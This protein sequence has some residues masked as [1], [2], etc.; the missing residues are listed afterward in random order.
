MQIEEKCINTIRFLAVDSIQ[1][2]NSGHPGMPLGCAPLAHLLFSRFMNHNPRNPD[3]WNRDRFV[4]SA[5][6][7]SMLLYSILHLCGY[8]LTLDDLKNFRQWGSKTPGHPEYGHTPGVET[9]TGPLG[10]GIANMVGMAVAQAFLAQ[11]FN[12]EDAILLDHFIYGIAGDGCMMEGISHEA[13]SFAG[14]NKLGKIILF[15]DDNK[16]TID[17]PVALSMSEDVAQRFM[18]Y[19][20]HVQNVHDVNDLD[21]V[22]RAVEEAKKNPAP[23]LIIT[24][25]EIGYGSPNKQAK[26]S[27][28]GSPLGIEETRLT[29]RNLGWPEDSSFLVP[30]DVAAFYLEVKAEGCRKESEWNAIWESYKTSHPEDAVIFSDLMNGY[31]GETWKKGLPVFDSG[32]SIATR[33]ASGKVLA[34]VAGLLPGIIGGSADLTPSN[35]THYKDAEDFSPENPGGRY[36]RFGIR[37]HAMGAIMNGMS[38]Y[39][40]LIPYGGTFLVFSDYLRPALRLAALSRIRV[41]YVFTHDSIGL[42][43]DGPT[44]QPIEHAA[45]LRAI[46]GMIV[47][48]PADAN[49]TAFSWQVAIEKKDGP[50]ALLLSRQNLP[51]LDRCLYSSAEKTLR[52]FYI[53]KDCSGDPELILL[54]SGSEVALALEAASR[55][56]DAGRKIRVVSCPCWELFEMQDAAYRESVLPRNVLKRISIEAGSTLGWERYVGLDG[57]C[58]GMHSFGASAPAE[59][60]FQEF[61]F[62]VEHVVSSA[63]TLFNS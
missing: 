54:A 13:A 12:R 48:R 6:H 42:G 4:L 63:E 24:R 53:L 41:I 40:G 10:Q 52:G 59:K 27:A 57:V 32:Q 26:S 5:G 11:K 18:S 38:M 2:A 46:P 62:T 47:L 34:A 45:S 37:E 51:V 15:Y 1:K 61:G 31:L 56:E 3:W 21:A 33:T 14:H 7:G 9:T 22:G 25:T 30:D 29:K 16:I 17:G 43:E 23:S 39:G 44:H 20:W 35:N 28:H 8:D 49:E 19:G 36:I 58:I 60:L 55:L 50:V